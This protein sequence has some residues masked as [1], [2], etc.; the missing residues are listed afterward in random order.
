MKESFLAYIW[1]ESV[2]DFITAPPWYGVLLVGI[3]IFAAVWTVFLPF[4]LALT[5]LEPKG[6]K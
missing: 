5:L 3:W 6:K 2:K 1:K 4:I